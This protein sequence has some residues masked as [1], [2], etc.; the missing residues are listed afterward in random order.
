M[1]SL[2]GRLR[3]GEQESQC[4]QAACKGKGAAKREWFLCFKQD[5]GFS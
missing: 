3:R 4:Q 2:S 1:R 5:T